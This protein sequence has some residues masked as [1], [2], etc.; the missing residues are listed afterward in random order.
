MAAK[1]ILLDILTE[2]TSNLIHKAVLTVD[3]VEKEYDIFRTHVEN[4]TVKKF[5]YLSHASGTVTSGRLI[6]KQMRTLIFDNCNITQSEDGLL[7][8]FEIRI[9]IKGGIVS[10]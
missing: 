6:D 2:F 5:I 9:S 8:L 1:K 3:G 4:G 10:E 7:V